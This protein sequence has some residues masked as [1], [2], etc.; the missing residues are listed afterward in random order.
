MMVM[1]EMLDEPLSYLFTW[2]IT[3]FLCWFFL[4][5]AFELLQE[6]KSHQACSLNEQIPLSSYLSSFFPWLA[7]SWHVSSLHLLF[8]LT[9]TFLSIYSVRAI[10]VMLGIWCSVRQIWVSGLKGLPIQKPPG[11]YLSSICGRSCGSENSFIALFYFFFIDSATLGLSYF[12]P[13][14][15][16]NWPSHM[17]FC[18][19]IS[20]HLAISYAAFNSQLG[21]SSGKPSLINRHG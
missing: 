6:K 19:P 3:C 8:D 4:F 7:S 12:L 2:T 1:K 13:P 20:Y 9:K 15:H 18:Q 11:L 16:Y 14:Q 21:I 5:R 17:L 10:L